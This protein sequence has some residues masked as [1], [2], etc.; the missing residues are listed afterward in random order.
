MLMEDTFS[1]EHKWLCQQGNKFY[2][3][4]KAKAS[5]SLSLSVIPVEMQPNNN[6]FDG[7]ML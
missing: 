7:T 6:M 3:F 2:P 1:F 5:L 4:C